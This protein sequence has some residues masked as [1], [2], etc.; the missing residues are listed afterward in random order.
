M[1]NSSVVGVDIFA[2]QIQARR[3]LLH[4]IKGEQD[5]IFPLVKESLT[6]FSSFSSCQIQERYRCEMGCPLSP[7][8]ETFGDFRMK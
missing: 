1:F 5:S 7:V 2:K 4:A 3:L 8:P 6:P